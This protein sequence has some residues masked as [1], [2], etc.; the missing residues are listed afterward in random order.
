MQTFFMEQDLADNFKLDGVI[1]VVDSK[2]V[3]PHLD[4]VGLICDGVTDPIS[5]V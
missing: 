3:T 2:H 5:A 1:T 4:E